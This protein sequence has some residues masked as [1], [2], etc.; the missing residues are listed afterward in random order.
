LSV[1]ATVAEAPTE[2]GVLFADAGLL[3]L[4]VKVLV[5]AASDR[6]GALSNAK[7]SVAVPAAI[8]VNS[9]GASVLLRAP[10]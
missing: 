1:S 8:E 9:V 3:A 2:T 4:S 7:P 6:L 10:L 5:G